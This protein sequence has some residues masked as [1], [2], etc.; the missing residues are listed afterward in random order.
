MSEELQES[1]R[2]ELLE[3]LGI[4]LPKDEVFKEMLEREGMGY[5]IR[6]DVQDSFTNAELEAISKDVD[7]ILVELA[8]SPSGLS[9]NE[10][11][12]SEVLRRESEK[13]GTFVF[14]NIIFDVH[15]KGYAWK[16][17]I[18]LTISSQDV[19]KA[20]KQAELITQITLIKLA[21]TRGLVPKIV[22]SFE[23][24]KGPSGK[25]SLS[26]EEAVA[27]I[28]EFSRKC[29]GDDY[30]M[31]KKRLQKHFSTKDDLVD[32]CS[33]IQRILTLFIDEDIARKFD[34]KS[35]DIIYRIEGD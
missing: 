29:L 30:I 22:I 27:E 12:I 14:K 25:S 7:E 16:G 3:K 33:E 2:Q 10:R 24:E 32:A 1:E 11:I 26:L 31:I 9:G 18:I 34:N 17:T 35:A 8:A 5:L 23:K 21:R 4:Y 13:L 15:E 28:E 20:Q 19:N 6:K